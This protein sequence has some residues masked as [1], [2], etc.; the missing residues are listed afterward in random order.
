MEV[1]TRIFPEDE[2]QRIMEIRTC[3]RNS[4]D[5]YIWDYNKTGAYTVKSGYWVQM[6]VLNR[7]LV[8]EDQPSLDDIYQLAWRTNT[9]PKIHHFLWRCI[10]N[11]IPIAGNMAWLACIFRRKQHVLD[12]VMKK[13]R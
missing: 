1:L 13:K 9:S 11:S 10:S 2:V 4:K 6:N 8:E 7:T 3:G 12:V 5:I